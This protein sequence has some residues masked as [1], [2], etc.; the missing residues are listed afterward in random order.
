MLL[1][2]SRTRERKWISPRRPPLLMIS[3][4]AGKAEMSDADVGSLIVLH[5]MLCYDNEVV[6]MEKST[7]L[8]G[9]KTPSLS[10]YQAPRHS[11]CSAMQILPLETMRTGDSPTTA[12]LAST[13][14]KASQTASVIV[15]LQYRRLGGITL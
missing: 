10:R 14:P 1:H 15:Q 4:G 6:M 13:G 9:A 3:N 7:P 8:L 5:E 2:H 11:A 12:Q